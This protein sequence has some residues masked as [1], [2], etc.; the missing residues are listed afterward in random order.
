LASYTSRGDY[1]GLLNLSA[2]G[3]YKLVLAS[4]LFNWLLLI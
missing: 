2:G 1:R 4:L 3:G